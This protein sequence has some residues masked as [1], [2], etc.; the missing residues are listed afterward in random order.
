MNLADFLSILDNRWSFFSSSFFYFLH[1][2]VWVLQVTHLHCNVQTVNFYVYLIHHWPRKYAIESQSHVQAG[3][4]NWIAWRSWYFHGEGYWISYQ[5]QS[6]RYT[7]IFQLR[8]AQH[9][10]NGWQNIHARSIRSP[11]PCK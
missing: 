1:T 11:I 3:H 7:Q 2:S 5:M 6:N 10:I 4:M 9:P 8:F